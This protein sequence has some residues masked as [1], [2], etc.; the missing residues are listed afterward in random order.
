MHAPAVSEGTPGPETRAAWRS[1]LLQCERQ[2]LEDLAVTASAEVLLVR[3]GTPGEGWDHLDALAREASQAGFVLAQV[4]L[5]GERAFDTLDA[6][7]RVSARSLQAPENP[8]KSRGITALLD[9]FAARHRG[10]APARFEAACGEQGSA[11]DL[12]LLAREYLQAGKRPRREALRIEAWLAGTEVDREDG[13]ALA[14]LSPR[15]ARRALG[16]LTRL[17]R[18]LGWRGT[19][20]FLSGGDVLSRLPPGRRDDALTVL[21]ELVDNADGG[22]GLVAAQLVIAGTAALF[23]GPRSLQSLRPLAMRVLPPPD[24]PRAL[25]PPHRPWVDLTVPEGWTPRDKPPAV[26]APSPG[27]S[28]ALR[29]LL[30]GAQGLPP[31]EAVGSM[32]VGHEKIDATI[33][34]L[35]DHSAMESSVFALLVGA[36]GTGKSHLL[37][38]LTARALADRRPVLRLSLERLDADLG[39][40]QRHLRRLLE[41][42]V[43]PLP[44]APSMLDHLVAWTRSREGL[45]RVLSVVRELSSGAGDAAPAARKLLSQVARGKNN[46]AVLESFLGAQELTTRASAPNYRQDAYHRLLLWLSLL[47]KL[48]KTRGPV[49]VI[50]EAENLYRGGTT[51]AERRTA[52]RSLSFYCGGTLPEACV[53]LAITPDALEELR[54]EATELLADVAEQ[55]TVL[56]WEDASMLQRRLT[57]LKPI[58]VPALT[59]DQRVVLAYRLQAAHAEARGVRADGRWA[60][61]VADLVEEDIPPREFVRRMVD[62]LEGAWWRG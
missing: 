52:L 14:A 27:V 3:H 8:L 44:G 62:R 61:Y 33:S 47:V 11:G 46:G 29:A 5:L 40:P 9:T 58:E 56:A 26:R 42:A 7:V 50:D 18:A 38:H 2:A 25:P 53:V 12:F 6:L 41:Q 22:R 36:Y 48:D 16:E 31:S 28:I 24:A 39:N 59:A 37:T 35:F 10:D 20:L 32:S 45:D 55:R 23:E 15:T 60:S 43:L 19:A 34:R 1:A 17:V 51:R 57:T 49:L 30:R 13:V 4:S 54:R 21:R